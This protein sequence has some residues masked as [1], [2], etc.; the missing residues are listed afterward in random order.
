MGFTQTKTRCLHPDGC[1]E[2]AYALYLCRAHYKMYSAE[3]RQT[4]L[5]NGVPL[6][7]IPPLEGGVCQ[8]CGARDW[9]CPSCGDRICNCRDMFHEGMRLHYQESGQPWPRRELP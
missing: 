2:E 5:Q 6:F 3:E 8:S 4:L 9:R 7:E 1:N